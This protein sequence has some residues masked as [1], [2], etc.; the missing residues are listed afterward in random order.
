MSGISSAASKIEVPDMNNTYPILSVLMLLASSLCK[1]QT[2]MNV[3]RLDGSE[4]RI[5]IAA[6]DSVHFVVVQPGGGQGSVVLPGNT[7]CATQHISVTGC[8]GL[9]YIHYE[10]VNYSLMEVGGQCWFADNLRTTR[11]NDGADIPHINDDSFWL[12]ASG[13]GYCY[14]DNWLDSAFYG[15]LYNGYAA[16]GT[17]DNVCPDGWHVPTDCDWMYLE[18]QLGMP[19]ATQLVLGP[20]GTDEGHRLKSVQSWAFDG[21]GTDA[22]NFNGRPGRGRLMIGQFYGSDHQSAGWWSST[23]WS[24]GYGLGRNLR[25][26]SQQVDRF[27]QLNQNGYHI[28]CV[29]D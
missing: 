20:R 6:I 10:G 17:T 29:R 18:G 14:P 19:A 9:G 28:R 15:L 25:F 16:Q 2:T 1:A 27:Y 4:M 13:P 24:T 22:V 23:L 26:D 3:H 7:D 8:Y 12:G 21:N 11:F 5:P